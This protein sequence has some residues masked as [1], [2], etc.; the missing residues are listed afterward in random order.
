M[1]VSES[2]SNRIAVNQLSGAEAK[3]LFALFQADGWLDLTIVDTGGELSVDMLDGISGGVRITARGAEL[4]SGV[5]AVLTISGFERLLSRPASSSYVWVEGLTAIVDTIAVRYAP[6]GTIDPFVP[7]DS[8]PNPAKVV[9][10]LNGQKAVEGLGRWLLV[11]SEANVS[12]WALAPW[13]SKAVSR[14]LTAIAHEVEPSGEL[15]FRGPPPARFIDAHADSVSALQFAAIQRAVRWAYENERELENRHGLLAAEIARTSLRN[16]QLVELASTLEHALEGAKI[17]Y[18]FGVTQQSKDTLRA[19]TDLRKA[20]SDDTAKLSEVTRS[21]STAVVGAVFA[22]IGVII[23]RLTISPKTQ[24]V[25]VAAL[26][27][28]GVL[29][30]YVMSM[31]ISGYHYVSIQRQLRRDWKEKLYRFLPPDEYKKMV[32]DPAS[33][34]ESGFKISALAGV[35][36]IILSSI[37]VFQI[38]YTGSTEAEAPT[39]TQSA[40]SV[41]NANR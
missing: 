16:G 33:R 11:D 15:L 24:Y 36:M 29:A 37:A 32:E 23:A 5:Q 18:N 25:G 6:W 30:I 17:A 14:L 4:P 9:R 1:V 3:E 12:D 40:P 26:I 10:V 38:A 20:I 7:A 13:R 28:A 34:A 41:N 35:V 39:S 27:L 8:L 22:N 21:I 31:I 2:G 19:L